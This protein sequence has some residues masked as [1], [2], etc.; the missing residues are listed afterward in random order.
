MRKM[1]MANLLP[2]TIKWNGFKKHH[3][4]VFIWP[5]ARCFITFCADCNREDVMPLSELTAVRK[6]LEMRDDTQVMCWVETNG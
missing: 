1:A 5:D 6:I 4:S 2:K 3:V